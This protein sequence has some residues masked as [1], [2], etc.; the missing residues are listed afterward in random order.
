MVM[1][2]AIAVFLLVERMHI[3]LTLTRWLELALG[4]LAT[5]MQR[6]IPRLTAVLRSIGPSDKVGLILLVVAA[7]V[8]VR[9]VR[10]RLLTMPRFTTKQCPRCG[11]D[12]H[13]IHRTGLDRVLNK[14]VPLR[15]YICCNRDCRW[16]GLRTGKS[17]P[18]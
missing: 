7:V 8:V 15:R 12:L 13:R 10:W 9:R 2:M 1:L 5:V 11:G 14:L 3:R 6:G 16:R 4:S 17:R 18:S